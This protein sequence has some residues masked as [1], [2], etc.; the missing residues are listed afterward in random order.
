M[1]LRLSLIALFFLLLLIV[2]SALAAITVFSVSSPTVT[3][4]AP[5]VRIEDAGTSGCVTTPGLSAT[6]SSLIVT[7]T[8]GTNDYGQCIILRNTASTARMFKVRYISGTNEGRFNDVQVKSDGGTQHMKWSG[9]PPTVTETDSWQTIAAGGTTSINVRE[10][11]G[12]GP[13]SVITS[14]IIVARSNLPNVYA[15]Y[16]L[17]ITFTAT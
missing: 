12:G 10:R 9:G 8:G 7:S 17:T 1:N 6:R 11:I 14:E 13:A 4:S 2:G 3:V 15:L 5:F 16:P